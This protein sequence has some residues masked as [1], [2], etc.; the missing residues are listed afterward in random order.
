MVLFLIIGGGP[1]ERAVR[2]EASR[3]GLRNMRFLPSQPA[4]SLSE[5]LGAGDLHL[6]TMREGTSGLVVPSKF[7]GVLAA[8]RPCLFVGPAD[9]EVALTIQGGGLGEVVAPGDAGILAESIL[10][11]RGSPDRAGKGLS[12]EPGCGGALS[13]QCRGTPLPGLGAAA[14]DRSVPSP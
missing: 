14:R 9:S 6:V 10:R 2:E 8:A 7:Y 11:Y 13:P 1:G 5:S 3:L 12:R 4:E